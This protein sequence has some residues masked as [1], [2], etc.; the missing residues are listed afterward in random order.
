[1]HTH[2]QMKKKKTQ[3]F[4]SK[5]YHRDSPWALMTRA[6]SA[7]LCLLSLWVVGKKIAN[8][9]NHCLWLLNVNHKQYIWNSLFYKRIFTTWRK[10]LYNQIFW[11][12]AWGFHL[13]ISL[14]YQQTT[15]QFKW[16][17][18]TKAHPLFLLHC[19]LMDYSLLLPWPGSRHRKPI[20]YWYVQYVPKVY[21]QFLQE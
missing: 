4:H 15:T 3:D 12:S 2:T 19:W 21:W 17:K 6:G 7:Q 13:I 14:N 18:C 9:S 1:M 16:V 5:C 8:S 10:E 20:D 11:Q